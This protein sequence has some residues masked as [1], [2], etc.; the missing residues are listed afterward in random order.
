MCEGRHIY[1]SGREKCIQCFSQQTSD[2]GRDLDMDARLKLIGKEQSDGMDC[3][4]FTHLT[5]H[6]IYFTFVEVEKLVD[7]T[8]HIAIV[9]V[10]YI[11][12]QLS[13]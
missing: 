5:V 9:E 13:K 7:Q 6:L 2:V 12:F 4:N 8:L 1:V 11:H 3:V 10:I